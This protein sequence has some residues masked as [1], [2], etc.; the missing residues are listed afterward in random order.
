MNNSLILAALLS[1]SGPTAGEH[2]ASL[3]SPISVEPRVAESV[4]DSGDR[5]P[6]L[7]PQRVTVAYASDTETVDRVW[8]P[9]TAVQPNV[10]SMSTPK[11]V[12]AIPATPQT[13]APTTSRP[14]VIELPGKLDLPRYNRGVIAAHFQAQ[15]MSLKTAQR[16]ADGNIV[17]GADG[18]PVLVPLREGMRVSEGQILGNF[19]TRLLEAQRTSAL[20][21]FKVAQAEA[22]KQIEV[23]YARTAVKCE[24]ASLAILEAANSQHEG[25]ITKLEILQSQL[26]VEQAVASYQLQDYN[27]NIV[28]KEEM[29]V[30]RQEVEM[31]DV[32]IGLRQLV[33]PLSGMIVK[34]SKAEGEWL[35][36]GDEVL[37]IVHLDTLQ[38]V[39][40]VNANLY[41]AN[42]VAGKAVS[43]TAPLA[44]GKMEVFTGKV[45]FAD[46]K[47]DSGDTF[48]VYIEVQNRPVGDS[49]L[50]QPGRMVSAAIKL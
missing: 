41:D 49:W 11:Q 18:Q 37:E 27:L 30:Q 5:I 3:S 2:V 25:A 19:D 44:N 40:K 24:Q 43:V 47:I 13:F 39:C 35:R 12:S 33:A 15:L 36:E 20:C 4:F 38:V 14:G 29:N 17:N 31:V 32:M 26:K 1:L 28:K 34:I 22:E 10:P 46:P 9:P 48:D 6:V 7:P 16:D 50:L 8:S 23:E 42:S 45:V 21:K